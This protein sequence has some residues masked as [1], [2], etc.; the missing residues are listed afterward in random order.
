MNGNI[1]NFLVMYG[2]NIVIHTLCYFY[3][4]YMNLKMNI[5]ININLMKNMNIIINN[6]EVFYYVF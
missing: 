2:N 3:K 4:E 5:S 6:N 1:R